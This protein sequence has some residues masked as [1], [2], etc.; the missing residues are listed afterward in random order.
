MMTERGEKWRRV[1]V[2]FDSG[3]TFQNG[4]TGGR[5]LLGE[6]ERLRVLGAAV[7]DQ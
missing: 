4:K 3:P 6:V 5:N 2:L 1:G 7:L